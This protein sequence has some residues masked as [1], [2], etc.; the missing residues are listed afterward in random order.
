MIDPIGV[1]AL[2]TL[3]PGT[4]LLG[5]KAYLS[6]AGFEQG[7]GDPQVIENH[8]KFATRQTDDGTYAGKSTQLGAGG[9]AALLRHKLIISGNYGD[10]LD[11][12][13]TRDWENINTIARVRAIQVMHQGKSPAHL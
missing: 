12:I 3:D 9:R 10:S 6:K 8:Q 1:E 4:S 11:D 2:V 5:A 13:S 7:F